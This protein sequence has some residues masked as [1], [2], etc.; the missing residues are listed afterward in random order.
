MKMKN[1]ERFR[2][3]GC[4]TIL[5][6]ICMVCTSLWFF[7]NKATFIWS[8]DGIS[9]HYNALAY[10]GEY[11]RKILR[12]LIENQSLVVP[13]Y[14]FSIGYGA[15]IFNTLQ[16]YVIGD[17]LNLL[18][19]FVPRQYTEI[20]F[21]ALVIVRIYLAGITFSVFARSRG[22]SYSAV[23]AGLPVYLFS[24]YVLYFFCKHPFF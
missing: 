8:V 18:A 1:T 13:T 2:F 5:F 11:L 4:Y 6:I 15:D 21:Q 20:L 7:W 12:N 10:Y 19:S 9:Q 3:Y 22:N 16:Y 14:D 23:L 17:P 24:E